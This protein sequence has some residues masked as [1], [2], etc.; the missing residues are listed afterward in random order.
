LRRG[1]HARAV[2]ASVPAISPR[3]TLKRDLGRDVVL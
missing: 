1:T 3:G 2:A